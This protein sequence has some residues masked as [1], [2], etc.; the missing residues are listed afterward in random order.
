MSVRRGYPYGYTGSYSRGGSGKGNDKTPKK[1]PGR[2]IA[3]I[4]VVVLL[5]AASA[6]LLTREGGI[7]SMLPF[8]NK[9]V[10]LRFQHNGQEVLLLPDSQVVVNPRDTLQLIQIKTDGWLSWGTRMVSSDMDVRAITKNPA[11]IK[12]LFPQD[13]FRDPQTGRTSG[14]AL[15]PAHWEGVAPCPTRRKGLAPESK[16]NG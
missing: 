13:I 9:L 3:V 4:A 2:I 11:A 6:L 12:D 10:A 15:E 16:R 8:P 1:S 14:A 5:G 7:A